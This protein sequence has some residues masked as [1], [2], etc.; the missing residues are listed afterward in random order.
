MATTANNKRDKRDKVTVVKGVTPAGEALYPRLTEPDTKFN[1]E[2]MYSVKLKLPSDDSATQDLID[3]IESVIDEAHRQAEEEAKT[4]QAKARIKRASPSYE[5]ELDNNTGE[6]SGYITF[7]F[8]MKA[9][10][11]SK[12]GKPWVRKP[13]IF[14]AKGNPLTDPALS[15]W[16]GSILK[17]A[18]ELT[19]F[20]VPALGVG[21]SQKLTAV[22][23]IELRSGYDNSADSYGFGVEEGF[24]M[25][26]E[27]Q[28]EEDTPFTPLK[29]GEAPTDGDF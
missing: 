19:P 4:P 6:P 29:A 13:V 26:A 21:C 1:P 17:V 28:T 8:K 2:G 12:Q 9:S 22:Q 24:T 16:G 27:A 3:L 15:I 14:D 25:A 20:N 5:E 7:N 11:V 23:V 10:G 18:F